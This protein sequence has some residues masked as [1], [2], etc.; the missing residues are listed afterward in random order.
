MDRIRSITAI[1]RTNRIFPV[2]IFTLFLLNIGIFLGL[3][4]YVTPGVEMLERQYLRRQATVRQEMQAREA[5]ETPLK[6]YRRGKEDLTSFYEA[7][8]SRERFTSL[9]KEIFSLAGNAG[10]NI[11]QISYSPEALNDGKLLQYTLGFSIAGDYRQIKKF[12]FSLEQSRRIIAIEGLS[13]T[14]RRDSKKNSESVNLTI[15]LSTFFRTD[16]S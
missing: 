4:Y 16:V 5:A 15:R 9:I 13:L 14:G 10:L 1:W 2:S 12:I 8:P 11:E 7:V 3:T 6:I